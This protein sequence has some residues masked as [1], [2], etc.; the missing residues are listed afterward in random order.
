MRATQTHFR[1]AVA[2]RIA[3][4][5]GCE[6]ATTAIE[7]AFVAPM[8]V[9]ILLA[10]MQVSVIF[11]AQSYLETVTEK[12]MRVVLTNQAYSLTQSQ[13]NA[14]VCAN[15]TALFNCN[16]LIV[17]LTPAPANAAAMAAAMPQFNANGALASPT[18]FN[19]GAPNTKMLLTVMYQWP[20]VGGPLG[21]NFS[22]LGNGEHLLSSS[23]VFYVEPCT[24]SSGCTPNG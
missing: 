4:Y 13:F 20:V 24:N 21:L 1:R 15:V 11:T 16:N 5:R 2:L 23:Q 9:A 12:A 7:F 3:K 18:T 6:R 8:M 14:E 17:Q 19:P 10:I 22:S